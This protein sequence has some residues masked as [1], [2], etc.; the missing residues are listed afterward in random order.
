DRLHALFLD[1]PDGAGELRV[2]LGRV[3]GR[4]SGREV[5]LPVAGEALLDGQDHEFA[6]ALSTEASGALQA[7]L[8]AA[9]ARWQAED[10]ARRRWAAV[11]VEERTRRHAEV[12]ESLTVYQPEG[13]WHY[14]EA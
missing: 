8:D 6:P 2:A 9:L 5:A 7:A 4:S 1:A 12:G 14:Q 3:V 13:S 11:A 10:A